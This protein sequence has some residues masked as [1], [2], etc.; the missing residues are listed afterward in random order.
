M[1]ILIRYFKGLRAFIE[2][3]L[4]VAVF[5]LPGLLIF[6]IVSPWQSA[7]K[8]I[9]SRFEKQL[10]LCVSLSSKTV[11]VGEAIE[12]RHRRGYILLPH[13]LQ[14]ISV[15]YATQYGDSP[16][17]LRES[18]LAFL[19]FIAVYAGILG[20]LLRYGLSRFTSGK[21]WREITMRRT[22]E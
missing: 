2:I 11:N 10:H 14:S 5:L 16:I 13:S 4:V 12:R 15:I 20:Y 19:M 17:E 3:A 21:L 6:N 9:E 7:E 22:P 1:R 8:L 18:S